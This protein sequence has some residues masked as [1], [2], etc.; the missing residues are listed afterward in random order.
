MQLGV[1]RMRKDIKIEKVMNMYFNQLLLVF[2]LNH[3]FCFIL[4]KGIIFCIVLLTPGLT[5]ESDLP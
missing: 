5:K 4:L 3:G 1:M 2:E